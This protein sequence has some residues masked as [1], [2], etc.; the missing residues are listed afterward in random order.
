VVKRRTA[1]VLRFVEAGG[2][3][4][5]KARIIISFAQVISQ[6]DGVFDIKYPDFYKAMLRLLSQFNISLNLLPTECIF[7]WTAG[8]IF[9]LVFKTLTPS[10]MVSFLIFASR[11]LR[12]HKA[13]EGRARG[14]RSRGKDNNAFLADVCGDLWFILLFLMYPS[15]CATIFKVSVLLA[16]APLHHHSYNSSVTY[17]STS[18]L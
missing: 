5:V 18:D 15:T 12:G 11:K 16:F 3:F 9:E 10:L 4:G 6:V 17:L 8:F 13:S 2:R 1:I 7:P 14:S